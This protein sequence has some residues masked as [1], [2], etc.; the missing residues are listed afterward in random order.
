[1][2]T[3]HPDGQVNLVSPLKCGATE[4]QLVVE[5][6]ESSVSIFLGFGSK[7]EYFFV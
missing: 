5:I 6:P 3:Q 4:N 2:G 1:M 7:I